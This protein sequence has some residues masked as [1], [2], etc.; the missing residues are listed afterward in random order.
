MKLDDKTTT[1]LSNNF[2][3]FQFFGFCRKI[4]KP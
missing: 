2:P 1:R 4:G 3:L